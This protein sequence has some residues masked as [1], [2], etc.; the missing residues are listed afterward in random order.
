MCCFP[1]LPA[2]T[3]FSNS[4]FIV[5][6]KFSLAV[7]RLSLLGSECAK[8][9]RNCRQRPKTPHGAG[10]VYRGNPRT[11]TA[12]LRAHPARPPPYTGTCLRSGALARDARLAYSRAD[13]G[14]DAKTSVADSFT[15]GALPAFLAGPYP[16]PCRRERN[17]GNGT[18]AGFRSAGGFRERRA[19]RILARTP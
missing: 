17:G 19:A 6:C 11:G 10:P 2:A 18:A 12:Q 1:T 8:T 13:P 5:S 7:E 16:G 15:A 14:P 3:S 9:K 4:S